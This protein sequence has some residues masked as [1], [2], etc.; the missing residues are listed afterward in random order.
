MSCG[1]SLLSSRLHWNR[2]TMG[3]LPTC[4]AKSR[5]G[6]GSKIQRGAELREL[7]SD[8]RS[9]LTRRSAGFTV[10]MM[11]SCNTSGWVGWSKRR[12]ERIEPK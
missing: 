10:K 8:W 1:S 4:A 9:G 2:L 12:L 11:M 6:R 7:R 3:R 5:A